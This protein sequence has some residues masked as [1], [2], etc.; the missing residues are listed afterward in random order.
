MKGFFICGGQKHNFLVKTIKMP[1]VWYYIMPVCILK[2]YLKILHSH[3]FLVVCPILDK[4]CKCLSDI[5]SHSLEM[6]DIPQKQSAFVKNA[7]T[8]S[9]HFAFEEFSVIW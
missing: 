5:S 6:I 2:E 4:C 9:L 3:P 1:A 8:W 7:Y